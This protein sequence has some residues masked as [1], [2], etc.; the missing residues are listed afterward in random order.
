MV[1]DAMS[2]KEIAALKESKLASSEVSVITEAPKKR[3][4]R[5]KKAKADVNAEKA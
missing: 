4:G 2:A 1:T 3:G 5:T